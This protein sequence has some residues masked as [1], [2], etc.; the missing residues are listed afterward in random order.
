MGSPR[1]VAGQLQKKHFKSRAAASA[2]LPGYC[3]DFENGL[4]TSWRPSLILL[5]TAAVDIG[6]SSTEEHLL[7]I[8]LVSSILSGMINNQNLFVKV[9]PTFPSA[10]RRPTLE[11]AIETQFLFSLSF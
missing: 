10:R 4:Q 2:H 3:P 9:K 8:V 11:S 5:S 6:G 1:G 7:S